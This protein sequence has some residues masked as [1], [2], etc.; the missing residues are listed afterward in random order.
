MVLTS[1]AEL[2]NTGR[3]TGYYL[4]EAAHAY[5]VFNRAGY[6]VDF[7]SPRGGQP[8]LDGLDLSD[9]L[10]KAFYEDPQV[11]AQLSVTPQPTQV[12]FANY[13][14]IFYAGG[15]GTMWDLPD[16]AE[17]A[18]ISTAIYEAGGVVGA[19]CHG[20]A[21][22]VNIKRPDGTYL[23]AG[24][25]VSMFTNEE[26][27]A[28]GLAEVVPFLLESKLIERGAR[29][30][31]AANFQTHAVASDRLVTGQNPASALRVAELIVEI[32]ERSGVAS[33][34]VG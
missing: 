12:D 18:Q 28:V 3:T 31:K 4:P 32:L 22:L 16:N 25:D 14:A 8:P 19:V 5:A 1:H 23:V 2:G 20:P 7:V 26:E 21:G 11:Q 13:D 24:K 9:P 34:Q 17:L 30:T 29:V 27:Q 33:R 10:S 15:H 6:Q